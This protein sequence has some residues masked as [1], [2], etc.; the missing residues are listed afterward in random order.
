MAS[1]QHGPQVWTRDL[2]HRPPSTT[3]ASSQRPRVGTGPSARW[4]HKTGQHVV[5]EET[6]RVPVCQGL[7]LGSG[8]PSSMHTGASLVGGVPPGTQKPLPGE[9][10]S[11]P[12]SSRWFP[13]GSCPPPAGS[14][15]R[16]AAPGGCGDGLQWRRG[17]VGGRLLLWTHVPW[18]HRGARAQSGLLGPVL[19]PGRTAGRGHG[20][21]CSGP[22]AGHQGPGQ[23]PGSH[24]ITWLRTPQVGEGGERG[25]PGLC[26]A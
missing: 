19:L 10:W 15:G 18:K 21:Q 23:A 25:Q 7:G 12:A 17:S 26:R 4:P 11:L 1:H 16:S 14:G 6:G 9:A 8:S 20:L 13:G 3:S 5:Q 24:P 22:R 2:G